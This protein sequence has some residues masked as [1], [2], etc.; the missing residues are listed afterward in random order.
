M[1]IMFYSESAEGRRWIS[2]EKNEDEEFDVV[3]KTQAFAEDKRK[4]ENDG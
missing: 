4:E 2:V 3:L 1:K